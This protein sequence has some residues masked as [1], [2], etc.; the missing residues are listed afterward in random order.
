MRKICVVTG[1]RAEY[2]LLR[3]LMENIKA[4]PTF[5]LQ[6]VVTGMHLSDNHGLTFHEIER[7]GFKID[8][9]I[10]ILSNS[11]SPIGISN[12][13][14]VAVSGFGK[15]FDELKPDLVILLGDRFET[16]AA[17][18]SALIANIPVAHIHGGESSEGLIDEA[19]RHAITK[20]SQIHFV[21]ANQYRNRVIQLGEQPKNVFLVG[22][23][24]V[25]CISKL[26]ILK[27]EELEDSLKFKF[28][29]RNLLVTFHPVTLEKSTAKLQMS[30]L[31]LA[32]S[33][34]KDTKILFTMPNS[35]TESIG[36]TKLIENF[37]SK[38]ENSKAF[39]S[40]GQAKY[41]SCIAQVDGVVG[42]SSSGLLEVPTFGRGT[43][44]IGDRQRGRL[45]AS[46]VIDCEPTRNEITKAIKK[47]YSN[48]FQEG[49]Q[50]VVNPYGESGASERIVQI[51]KNLDLNEIIKKHF[52]NLGES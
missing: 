28:G 17:A 10:P 39:V 18:T 6:V 37:V 2:G 13:I 8:L 46:S 26:K 20:M 31:L 1:T 38:H 27:K 5:I 36:I 14:G 9:K 48:D 50:A 7:D 43:I 22:G 3:F 15:A 25:D 42:N 33:D 45:K 49:L 35:D 12:S 29:N 44:N 47:L 24:G 4:D 40:L 41:F 32:L 52:Y 51:L 30:E 34:L 11:D 23:L 21:A 19:L 16:F